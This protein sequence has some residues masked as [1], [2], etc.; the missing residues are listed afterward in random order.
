MKLHQEPLPGQ[1]SRPKTHDHSD[2]LFVY[3]FSIYQKVPPVNH[4]RKNELFVLLASSQMRWIRGS[5]IPKAVLRKCKL[6]ERRREPLVTGSKDSVQLLSY[7]IDSS[8][9]VIL[10]EDQYHATCSP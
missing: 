8:I 3:L 1:S 9:K 4:Q 10:H 5:Q 2:V 7:L 6:S